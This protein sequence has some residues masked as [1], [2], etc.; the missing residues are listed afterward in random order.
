M[1]IRSRAL[2]MGLL[3]AVGSLA[4]TIPLLP[5]EPAS[6][7]LEGPRPSAELLRHCEEHLCR[8]P[9]TIRIADDRGLPLDIVLA[10][11]EPIVEEDMVTILPGETIHLEGREWE[12]SIVDL[13]AVRAVEDPSRTI[14]FSFWQEPTSGTGTDMMLRV[15]NGFDHLVKY[16]LGMQLPGSDE[17]YYTSSCPVLPGRLAYEHWSHVILRLFVSDLVLLDLP[18][19]GSI[20]C[21]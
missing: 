20:E 11:P 2:S 16:R 4:C 10:Q 15:E 3:L 13:R 19:D 21:D 9:Q 8:G 18:E 1:K 7:P 17:I 6:A 14:T 5:T 12:S